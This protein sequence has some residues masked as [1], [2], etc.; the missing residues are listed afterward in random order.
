MYEIV[1][2]LKQNK[3]EET[4][5]LYFSFKFI[6]FMERLKQLQISH[7]L[8]NIYLN[9]IYWLEEGNTKGAKPLKA[10]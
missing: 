9:H 4:K 5:R 10:Y 1:L 6:I 3:K 7:P 8:K 2:L